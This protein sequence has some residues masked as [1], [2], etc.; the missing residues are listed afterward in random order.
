MD[1]HEIQARLRA[2]GRTQTDLARH[3][4]MSHSQISRL[5][6]GKSRLRVETLRQ[7]EIFLAMAERP[8]RARG[9]EETPNTPFVHRPPIKSITLEQAKALRGKPPTRVSDEELELVRR[10]LREI[11]EA[12]KRAPRVTDLT[13]DEI[14]GYDQT[15]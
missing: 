3:L 8:G 11:G 2:T 15:P 4:G 12:L 6:S 9:V 14:L 7:I 1:V 10:E 13:D 5:L